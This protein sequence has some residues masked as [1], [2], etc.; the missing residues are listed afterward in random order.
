MKK[1]K[2]CSYCG[3]INSHW[4]YQCYQKNKILYQ[5]KKEKEKLLGKPSK[6]ASN[7]GLTQK[8]HKVSSRKKMPSYEQKERKRLI[9]ELD[10]YYSIY[11]RYSASDKNGYTTCYT[12]GIKLPWRQ[13]DAGHWQSRRYQQTRWDLDNIRP[14]SRFD[15][16][17]LGGN[18]KVYTPKLTAELGITKVEEIKFKAHNGGKMT[19]MDMEEKLMEIKKKLNDLI[20]ERKAKGWV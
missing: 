8:R 14:Q 16:R 19:T 2:K 5:R 18:Y 9:K 3:A 12:S 13:L 15:N 7:T 11:V 20:K 4:S 10:K 1:I 6:T 17:N